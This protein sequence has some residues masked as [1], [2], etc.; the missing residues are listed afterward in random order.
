M[1]IAME[2]GYRV[3]RK[4][5]RDG[6]LQWAVL[7]PHRDPMRKGKWEHV[8]YGFGPT[9]DSEQII[10]RIVTKPLASRYRFGIG[11]C[12]HPSITASKRAS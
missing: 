3:E 6:L 4:R 8:G 12:E 9:M 2:N 7:M 11:N 5:R 10:K 1:S